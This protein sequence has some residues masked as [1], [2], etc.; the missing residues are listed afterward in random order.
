MSS[1]R[2]QRIRRSYYLCLPPY[3]FTELM[4]K[5]RRVKIELVEK[6]DGYALIRLGDDN[7]VGERNKG[8]KASGTDS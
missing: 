6:G 5:S 1:R 3:F 7:G 4:L 8:D 2:L